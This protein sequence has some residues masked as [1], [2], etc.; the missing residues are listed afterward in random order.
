MPPTNVV[1]PGSV[2]ELHVAPLSVEVAKPMSDAPPSK[3]RPN[4][5]AA[6][7]VEPNE[8]VSGSTI[9]L[10]W[11]VAFVNG[12]N[13]IR[14]SAAFALATSGEARARAPARAMASDSR[15]RRGGGGRS[16]T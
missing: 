14:V 12:S 3:K 5:A 4:C 11:L 16:N 10:C 9:V 6:T 13:A 15:L 1:I 2:P 8:Y 7:I